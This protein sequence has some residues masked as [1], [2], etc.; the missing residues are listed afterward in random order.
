MVTV[1]TVPASTKVDHSGRRSSEAYYSTLRFH[2]R[3]ES[4]GAKKPYP[5]DL[6]LKGFEHQVDRM[7][8]L[9]THS[10]K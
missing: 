7:D 6:V 5:Q 10:P 9:N 8:I 4:D 1:C 2:I 3:L